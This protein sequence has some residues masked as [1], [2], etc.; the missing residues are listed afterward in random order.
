MNPSSQVSRILARQGQRK[1]PKVRGGEAGFASNCRCC[2]S[3]QVDDKA[4]Q[5]AVLGGIPVDGIDMTLE[6]N[7]AS[8][9]ASSADKLQERHDL[10]LKL[11]NQ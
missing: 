9:S 7:Y 4:T 1:I 5:H 6:G 8:S 2:P 3:N 11:G 10:V